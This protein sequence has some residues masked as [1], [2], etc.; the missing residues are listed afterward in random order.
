MSIVLTELTETFCTD[1][2]EYAQV[3]PLANYANKSKTAIFA[4]LEEQV[5]L[6]T[7]FGQVQQSDRRILLPRGHAQIRIIVRPGQTHNPE[8]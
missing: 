3:V 4:V 5:I 8:V 1:R 6:A 7:G 2:S